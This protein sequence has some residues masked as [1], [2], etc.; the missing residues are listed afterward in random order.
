MYFCIFH[1]VKEHDGNHYDLCSQMTP[2]LTIP[3]PHLG[4][5]SLL[6]PTN[7][8][9]WWESTTIANLS[10]ASTGVCSVCTWQ[11]VEDGVQYA[12]D[13]VHLSSLWNH[14]TWF[15]FE[16]ENICIFVSAKL[17]LKWCQHVFDYVFST[18][19]KY[20]NSSEL[21]LLVGWSISLQMH[22]LWDCIHI[23]PPGPRT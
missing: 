5:P 10:A 2:R 14:L 19:S 1:I 11:V 12:V 23:L 15:D 8:S 21:Y 13:N 9:K 22:D 6:V 16:R 4:L 17:C 18:K 7:K 3:D 20:S